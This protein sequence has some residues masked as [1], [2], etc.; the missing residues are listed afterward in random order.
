MHYSVQGNH[1]HLLV[2]ADA[3]RV[4]SRRM[5]GFSV[6]LAKAVNRMM[7]RRRGRVLAE[8]YHARTLK[9]PTE[10]RNALRYV[11]LNHAKH[12]AQAGKVG[13][14]VDPY[15]SGPWFEGWPEGTPLPRRL[16]CTG[17]PTSAAKSFLLDA[18]WK[19]AR[20]ASFAVAMPA[21]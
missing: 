7:G 20:G 1:L 18:G 2:E 17:P 19:R 15:S 4:L 10:A 6:R 21:C 11:L 13:M 5:Q 14:V 16:P 3:T 9:T 12:S 8:R